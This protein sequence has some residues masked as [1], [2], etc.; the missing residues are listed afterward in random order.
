MANKKYRRIKYIL[1]LTLSSLFF[2]IGG[3]ARKEVTNIN[4]QGKNIICFGD[5]ITFGYGANPGEA[6][7]DALS[8]MINIPVVSSGLDGDTSTTAL[9]RLKT[10][11][12]DREPLLVIIEFGGNDFLR[13]ISMEETTRNIE[14]MIKQIQAH[15]AMT[16]IADI[17]VGIIMGDYGKEFKHLCKKY[18]A[19]YIPSLFKGIITNPSLKSDFIHPNAEGYKVIAQRIYRTI[20][21][22]LNQNTLS[23]KFVK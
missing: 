13:K 19:I 16:A 21:P 10:D 12:L 18:N 14:E 11:V 3:C 15:G 20:I 1:F 9:M 6:F 2:A 17:S 5:S 7:P 23:R 4:S 8:K 22:Y